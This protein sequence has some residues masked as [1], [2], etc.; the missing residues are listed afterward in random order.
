MEAN[1]GLG[2]A[3]NSGMEIARGEFIGFVDSDDWVDLNMFGCPLCS[4]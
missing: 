3:R 1:G 2:P 4:N